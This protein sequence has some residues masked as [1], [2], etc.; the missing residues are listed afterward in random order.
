MKIFRPGQTGA[1]KTV[2]QPL[3]DKNG[4]GQPHSKT[5]RMFASS[6]SARSVL[7]CGCPLPLFHSVTGLTDTPNRTLDELAG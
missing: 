2:G 4:R 6:E 3:R 5:C 1:M 7:E